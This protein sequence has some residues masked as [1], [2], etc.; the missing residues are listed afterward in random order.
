MKERFNAMAGPAIPLLC[1]VSINGRE[2][3]S[4]FSSETDEKFQNGY[5]L[6]RF[7]ALRA[8]WQLHRART[9]ITDA[10][11]PFLL[12][13]LSLSLCEADNFALRR[14][15]RARDLDIEKAS[16]L[17]FKY[18]KW[19]RQSVPNGFISES[20][21]QNELPQRKLFMQGFDKAGRPILVGFAAKHDYSKR[22]MDEFKRKNYT[23]LFQC[24]HYG[25]RGLRYST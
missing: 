20:E 4:S 12:L 13:S 24:P 16:S 5:V 6:R 14:F 11:W 23:V 15:L 22:H 17:F 10:G 3:L 8:A 19:R 1:N 18:L 21:I 2:N 9:E 25:P 7:V